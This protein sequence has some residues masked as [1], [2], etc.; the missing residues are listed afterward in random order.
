MKCPTIKATV[1]ERQL[2]AL[3]LKTDLGIAI[4]AAGNNRHMAAANGVNVGALTI[5]GVAL[6]NGMAGVSGGLV[7]QYQGFSDIG[8]GIG[9]IVIGLAS[10]IIGESVFRWR[11]LYAKVFAVI[12][13]NTASAAV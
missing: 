12:D 10:V 7:A 13:E 1:Q 4:R 3:F 6:A 11:S 9:T 8:M 5:F 2:V